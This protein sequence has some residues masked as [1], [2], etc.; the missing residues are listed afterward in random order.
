MYLWHFLGIKTP[1]PV[2]GKNVSLFFCIDKCKVHVYLF[3]WE[4]Q[5]ITKIV[6]PY[7]C[8]VSSN[9]LIVEKVFL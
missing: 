1:G 6:N 4:Y 9:N 5:E 8:I 2:V 7:N 3:C